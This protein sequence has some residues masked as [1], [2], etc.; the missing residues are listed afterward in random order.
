MKFKFISAL[1]IFSSFNCFSQDDVQVVLQESVVNKVLR[2]IGNF[3]DTSRYSVLFFHGT[4]KW[5]V[6]D[7][8]IELKAN[9]KA[10][11]RCDV[12][13]EAGFLSY[14]DEVI[15]D[16]DVWYDKEKNLINIKIQHGLFEIYTHIFGAKMHIKDVDLAEYYSEPLTFEGPKT[17]MSTSMDF[18]MPDNSKKTIYVIPYECSLVVEEKKII[19]KCEMQ[20]IDKDPTKK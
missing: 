6:I 1:V 7:P 10:E 2:A 19:V 3:S 8:K 4:Y 5:T 12:Q 18:T 17:L 16:A 11:F 15:G 14:R 9:G 20:F 13:V